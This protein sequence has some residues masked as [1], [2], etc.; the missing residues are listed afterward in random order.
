MAPSQLEA[1]DG[2]VRVSGGRKRVTYERL[3]EPEVDGAHHARPTVPVVNP[4]D[5]V[6]V[7]QSMGRQELPDKVFATFEYV[8][9]VR[10]TEML[11]GRVIRPSG[12]N[13]TFVS[14][15]QASV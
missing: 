15:D 9:D 8:Q 13:D 12:R 10:L 1:S 11:H 2:M 4:D 3:F 7:G 14:F 6:I 5:Y